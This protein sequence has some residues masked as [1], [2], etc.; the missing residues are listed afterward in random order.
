MLL[1]VLRTLYDAAGHASDVEYQAQL[2]LVQPVH[3]RLRARI[4]KT[5]SVKP[6]ST[7]ILAAICTQAAGLCHSYVCGIKE[8]GALSRRKSTPMGACMHRSKSA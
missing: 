2:P 5:I 8:M 3:A 1:R 6:M 7:Q 4:P